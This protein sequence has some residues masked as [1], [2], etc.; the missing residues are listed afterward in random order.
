MRCRYIPKLRKPSWAPPAPIFGQV[1]CCS[2]T[3]RQPAVCPRAACSCWPACI[4]E[5]FRLCYM[6]QLSECSCPQSWRLKVQPRPQSC[7]WHPPPAAAAAACRPPADV[8]CAVWCDGHCLVPCWQA[9]WL[10][11]LPHGRVC[12][13]AAAQPGLAAPLL[14][15]EAPWCGTGRERR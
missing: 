2:S 5:S 1:R 11:L 7:W 4:S 8:G 3:A 15:D 12:G 10:A 14:P 9:G 13:A 6:V